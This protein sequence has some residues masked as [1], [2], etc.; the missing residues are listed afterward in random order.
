MSQLATSSL[1]TPLSGTSG[2]DSE[3]GNAPSLQWEKVP[4][5]LTIPTYAGP[6]WKDGSYVAG[7]SA[8]VWAGTTSPY[9]SLDLGDVPTVPWASRSGCCRLET[10]GVILR[11]S[12]LRLRQAS[13]DSDI[14]SR[15][16]RSSW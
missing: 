7:S 5:Y 13:T 12:I 16:T 9:H 2:L 3:F 15:T 11:M 14:L 8:F 10:H 4:R 1:L 6:S